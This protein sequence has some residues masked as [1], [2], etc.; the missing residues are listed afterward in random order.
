MFVVRMRVVNHILSI[1]KT[2]EMTVESSELATSSSYI[3]GGGPLK[4]R[5]TG[6]DAGVLMS[7]TSPASRCGSCT[8]DE[9]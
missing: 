3:D 6:L 1:Q 7:C 8:V 5:R 4:L 9:K 2:K